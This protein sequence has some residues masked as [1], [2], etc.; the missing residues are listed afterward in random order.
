MKEIAR[1]FACSR[2]AKTSEASYQNIS[3][4]APGNAMSNRLF[5][6]FPRMLRTYPLATSPLDSGTY[7][8]PPHLTRSAIT[9]SPGAMDG[10]FCKKVNTTCFLLRLLSDA[11]GILLRL[12]S[13]AN[14]T[15]SSQYV[16]VFVLVFVLVLCVWLI[17][18]F[19]LLMLRLM[20]ILS[21]LSLSVSVLALVLVLVCVFT[22]APTVCFCFLGL[23][24]LF[25]ENGISSSQTL[26]VL[27]LLLL[28]VDVAHNAV[29]FCL[30]FVLRGSPRFPL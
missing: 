15:S 22:T 21:S 2:P 12:L 11:N 30:R 3:S 7:T 1:A 28:L 25:V 20:S 10:K 8:Q 29:T 5:V 19:C 18:C 4:I 23:V 14:G 17:S 16:L 27:M 24:R 26:L 9:L 6:P 13:D